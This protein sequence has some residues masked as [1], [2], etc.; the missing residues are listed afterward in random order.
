MA[1]LPRKILA[2]MKEA[3]G[4]CHMSE[5]HGMAIGARTLAFRVLAQYPDEAENIEKLGL[6][7]P[8]LDGFLWAEAECT[9]PLRRVQYQSDFRAKVKEIY[10]QG[11]D[12]MTGAEVVDALVKLARDHGAV[13]KDMCPVPGCTLE[14]AF[15]GTS[16][17][18][19]L[20]HI[21]QAL[22]R[23]KRP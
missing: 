19:C 4:W 22:P 12:G 1:K 17:R 21:K 16:D 6:G 10:D 13:F 5:T 23:P 14:T 20:G 3:I 8:H 7:S 15:P 11:G 18:H 2:A 9:N